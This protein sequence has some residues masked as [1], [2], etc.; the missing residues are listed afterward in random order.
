[1]K[2]EKMYL[3]NKGLVIKDLVPVNGLRWHSLIFGLKHSTSHDSR[4]LQARSSCLG[5]VQSANQFGPSMRSPI[6]KSD[7][8]R[9]M[10]IAVIL[11][12]TGSEISCMSM[13]VEL[14]TLDA[15]ARLILRRSLIDRF[16]GRVGQGPSGVGTTE[17]YWKRLN[18]I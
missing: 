5:F 17:Y 4:L 9:G 1:M 16:I 8:S 13:S 11:V 2:R 6:F 18:F 7:A 10:D 15:N 12:I 14:E 3:E